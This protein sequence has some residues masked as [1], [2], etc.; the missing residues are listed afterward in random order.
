MNNKN[1]PEL[2]TNP[3]LNSSSYKPEDC[4]IGVI[5]IGVGNFHRAHQAVY[6]D[7]ILNND[8][9]KNWGIAGINL[10]SEQSAS[11]KAQ[12][13]S[14][15]HYVLKTVS[16]NGDKT[17]DE[18]KS[19]LALYDWNDEEN[20][21]L[22]LFSSNKVQLITIT[23]TESG[24]Y[25]E[26]DYHLNL[27]EKDI[28]DDLSGQIPKTI[29]GAL[30]KGLDSRM[31][32]NGGPLTVACCDNLEG[33]GVMLERFFKQYLNE[34]DEKKLLKWVEKNVSFPS[35]MVDRI[36]PKI[37]PNE[38]IEIQNMF[39]RPDDCSVSSEDFI[40]WVIEDNFAGEKPP[41][42]NVGVEIVNDVEPYENTKIRI[43]NGGHTILA[44]FGVLRGY[45][46]FDASINDSELS[47]FFDEIQTKE[48]LPSL[49]ENSPVDYQKYLKT[50]KHRFNNK[51]LP[52]TLARICM[53]GASKFPIFLLPTIEWHLDK[54][55]I[56]IFSLRAIASWYVF[57]CKVINHDVSFDYIEPKWNMLTPF[58]IEGGENSFA[59]NSDL[60][61]N[62]P[63]KYPDFVTTL[64]KEIQIMKNLYNINLLHETKSA[65]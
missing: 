36:T 50:T 65:I 58:L 27:N 62:V 45:E 13:N 29:F 2:I 38:L 61:G 21:I 19:I 57:L 48:I 16:S 25:F 17:Y 54:G 64:V 23:V 49:P 52:D 35:S 30:S 10:R 56:P 7:S 44:Y 4:S 1:K 24:Y 37:N 22:R 15:C 31:K 40:Q 12:K 8:I 28:Q 41:L 20:E 5:H 26:N 43:L 55:K 53:D 39:S 18:I 14:N 6:F 63:E 60:W 33:N 32:N 34:L 51:Y 9:S 42:D 46:T 47:N 3:V 11:I 59:S